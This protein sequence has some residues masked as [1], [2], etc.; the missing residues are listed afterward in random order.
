MRLIIIMC[1]ILLVSQANLI[2]VNKCSLLLLGGKSCWLAWT[3]TFLLSMFFSQTQSLLRKILSL[4]LYVFDQKEHERG[5]VYESQQQRQG[6]LQYTISNQ[7]KNVLIIHFHI[8]VFA[9]NIMVR[10]GQEGVSPICISKALF[11]N[12]FWPKK[13]GPHSCTE[14]DTHYTSAHF[15]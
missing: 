14:L 7:V 5:R 1:Q 10:E 6:I 3:I 4:L 15:N 9:T 2:Y 12:A 8:T 11:Q 13:V